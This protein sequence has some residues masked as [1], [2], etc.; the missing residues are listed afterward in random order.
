M[1]VPTV[2]ITFCDLFLVAK[3]DNA[4][5]LKT[6]K[7]EEPKVMPV[8]EKLK[9]EE[10][11]FSMHSHADPEESIPLLQLHMDGDHPVL[12]KPTEPQD[13]KPTEPSSYVK[14][15]KPLLEENGNVVDESVA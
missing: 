6:I 2:P 13:T 5:A 8:P 3:K 7:N 10:K 1:P 4:F 11:R 15:S 9:K 12:S 14:D